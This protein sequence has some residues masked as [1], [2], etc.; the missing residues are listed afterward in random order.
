MDDLIGTAEIARMAGVSTRTVE[1][2][3]AHGW[4]P[5]QAEVGGRNIWT[6][7]YAESWVAIDRAAG[8]TAAHAAPPPPLDLIGLDDL[9]EMAGCTVSSARW[10]VNNG[11]LPMP[12]TKVS[13]AMVWHRATVS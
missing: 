11:S 7:G 4:L 2:W 13:G 12:D 9:A 8:V 6:R 10:K 1:W 5:V 3:V